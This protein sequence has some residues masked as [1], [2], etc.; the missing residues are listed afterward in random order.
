MFTRFEKENI[1]KAS[2]DTPV[3]MVCGARQ[4]GKSTLFD[5][6]RKE[7]PNLVYKTFDDVTTLSIAQKNPQAFLE[8]L[9]RPLVLDEV[10]HVPAL[11][12]AIKYFVDLDRKPGQFFLTGSANVLTIPKISE[13]LAGRIEIQT[14]WPLSQGEILG[15]KE[16]FIDRIFR[17]DF[18]FQSSSSSVDY[19]EILLKGGYP[20]AV[21]RHPQRR[22]SWFK[23]YLNTILQRDISELSKIEGL[24]YI[25][26]L[27]MLLAA[28]VGS[29][30]NLSDISRTLGLSYTTLTRYLTLLESIFIVISLKPWHTNLSSQIVKSDKLYLND[31]GLLGSLL[32]GT[33]ELLNSNRKIFGTLLEN[34]VLME[35]MKQTG[36][37]Q[38]PVRLFHFRTRTNKEVDFVLESFDG[39]LVGIEVKSTS[40]VDIKNCQGLQELKS[41][42]GDRFHRGIVLYTGKESLQFEKDMFLLPISDLWGR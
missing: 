28:R 32:G 41:I 17:D 19:N 8:G 9:A 4:T 40:A 6:L 2:R 22:F 14:L 25:P 31:S 30:S 34:F 7:I 42:A 11:F 10:Q 15:K 12:Q 3:I 26:D 37:N 35:L 23:N 21:L 5:H 39:R 38:T 27:L 29:L 13:S 36:W 18:T 16:D 20:E 24:S 33:P 1:L